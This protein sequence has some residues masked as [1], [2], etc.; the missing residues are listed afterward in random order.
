MGISDKIEIFICELLK[1]ENDSIELKRNEL[2]SVFNCVPSQI[3]Y[4]ISTRFNPERGYLVE[5]RR[6]GGGFIRITRVDTEDVLANAVS[7]IGSAI[8][9]QTAF[10]L[11][12][13]LYK[14]NGIDKP[15]ADLLLSCISD[16]S[17][18]ISQPHRDAVRASILKNALNTY[19]VS[20]ERT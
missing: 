8:D 3:N 5:S 16:R 6:G 9:F 18:C 15:A 20:K 14:Q 2:A 4:V 19:A 17:I 1:N 7:Q 10:S 11:I 13:Y 12:Q